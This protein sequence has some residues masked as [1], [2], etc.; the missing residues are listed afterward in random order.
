MS[1]QQQTTIDDPK[2]IE[3]RLKAI[4]E[5]LAEMQAQGTNNAS[6]AVDAASLVDPQDALNCE[7]CQ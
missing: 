5:A 3:L 6:T 2:E 7:G 4:Q 1:S